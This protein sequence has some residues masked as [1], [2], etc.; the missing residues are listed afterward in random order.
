MDQQ[1]EFDNIFDFDVRRFLLIVLDVDDM[2]DLT[3]QMLSLI[4]TLHSGEISETTN[5]EGKRLAIT[6]MLFFL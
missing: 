3:V 4:S 1:K 5:D 6:S 2:A